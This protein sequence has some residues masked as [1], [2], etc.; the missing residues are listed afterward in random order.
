MEYKYHCSSLQRSLELLIA[1]SKISAE[2]RCDNNRVEAGRHEIDV[3]HLKS[4]W[5]MQD[6]LCYYSSIPM[7]FDKSEWRVSIER[8]NNKKGY[9]VG[10]VVLCCLEFN[11]NAQWTLEKV[12]F[13]IQQHNGFIF[14]QIP[15]KSKR[16]K[17]HTYELKEIDPTTNIL[18]CVYCNEKKNCTL[19][20][21]QCGNKCNECRNRHRKDIRGTSTGAIQHLIKNAQK[22]IDLR[23]NA[24]ITSNRTDFDIDLKF[25]IDLHEKQKGVCAYSGLPLQ[26]G[27]Y[28]D[29]DWVVSLE[30]IDIKQGYTKDNVCLICIEFNSCDQSMKTGPEYGCAG[31]SPLKFE[32]F[33]AH[34][35]YKKGLICKEELQAVIDHQVVVK[36]RPHQ[37]YHNDL[38]AKPK[39]TY[40]RKNHHHP[41]DLP[42]LPPKEQKFYGAIYIITTLDGKQF[43]GQAETLNQTVYTICNDIKRA[44]CQSMTNA[45]EH[46]GREN[47]KIETI[48]TCTKDKLSFYQQHFIKEFNTY[49]P[50]GLNN[51]TNVKDEVR[52]KISKTLLDN[53]ERKDYDGTILPKYVKFINQKDQKGYA[54]VSHPKCK[55]RKFVTTDKNVSFLQLKSKQFQRCMEYLATL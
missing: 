36:T 28:L 52:A 20:V 1:N 5:K 21:K 10:N 55:Q 30:R 13:A 32:Y 3:E 16:R 41:K 31:W 49:E 44:G 9:V 40:K 29:K 8:L 48:L 15:L 25:L 47:M 45:I 11:G 39:L 43:V 33:V 38:P 27:S 46:Y 23:E 53:I 19:F 7:N 6:G 50:H 51:T 17:F 4:L 2:R 24:H 22:A 35:K 42:K 12:D 14:T 37:G 54:I 34:V 26:F 18:H